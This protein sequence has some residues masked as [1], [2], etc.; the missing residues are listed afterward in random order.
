MITTIVFDMGGVLADWNADQILEEMP[1][2]AQSKPLLKKEVFTSPEWVMVDAGFITDKDM[3]EAALRRLPV[4]AHEDCRFAIRHFTD[5][6]LHPIPETLAIVRQLKAAGYKL[7]LL[8]NA[9]TRFD[10]YKDRFEAFTYMDGLF[11]SAFH[12]CYKPDQGMYRKFFQTYGLDPAQCLFIDDSQANI[13]ASIMAGMDGIV[14]RGDA[15][16][17]KQN[18]QERG[19]TIHE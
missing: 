14:Y 17:L 4:W 19:I 5:Y 16:E 6:S 9:S 13:A 15:E 3:E 2:Q 10:E 7:Y 11:V 12:H 1:I 8:S 18:L